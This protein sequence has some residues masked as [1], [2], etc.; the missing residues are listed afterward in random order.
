MYFGIFNTETFLFLMSLRPPWKVFVDD[1]TKKSYY[2]N[3]ETK[4]T[5]WTLPEDQILPT[6][7][8]VWVTNEMGVVVS[9]GWVRLG[10]FYLCV[11]SLQ[12]AWELPEQVVRMGV[13]KEGNTQ[14]GQYA[15]TTT[16]GLTE[17]GNRVSQLSL[18]GTR[19]LMPNALA[20]NLP[21]TFEYLEN[22]VRGNSEVNSG[23]PTHK[24]INSELTVEKIDRRRN[25]SHGSDTSRS[26]AAA[27]TPNFGYAD[28]DKPEKRMHSFGL[29]PSSKPLIP[30]AQNPVK[31]EKIK[32]PASGR[33]YYVNVK[34]NESQ[35]D[36][37]S[38]YVD[39]QNEPDARSS[40][41]RSVADDS[42]SYFDEPVSATGSFSGNAL[43]SN[44]LRDSFTRN[45]VSTPTYDARSEYNRA[46]EDGV[47]Y[48]SNMKSY[49]ATSNSKSVSAAG[50]SNYAFR[51]VGNSG[52]VNLAVPAGTLKQ[53]P[54]VLAPVVA[55]TSSV[56]LTFS[57]PPLPS[58]GYSEERRV[59]KK[60]IRDEI[61]KF[62][63]QSF[64]EEH[65]NVF[66]KHSFFSKEAVLIGDMVKWQGDAIYKSLLK[67]S[68]RN[69]A[70]QTFKFIQ[71]FMRDGGEQ[72]RK[73]VEIILQE[74]G[75][76]DPQM[77]DEIFCQLVKQTTSN[78]K[79]ESNFLG[80]KLMVLCASAFAPSRVFE[81]H[82]LKYFAASAIAA[83]G[84]LLVLTLLAEYYVK[85]LLFKSSNASPLTL[86][87]LDHVL[88]CGLNITM[89]SFHCNIDL[90]LDFQ[91]ALGDTLPYPRILKILCESVI[92]L[93]G[94]EQ[95]GIFRLAGNKTEIDRARY[96]LEN[97]LE[98]NP[99]DPNVPADLL[100]Q[101]FRHLPQPLIPFEQFEYCMQVADKPDICVDMINRICSP[102]QKAV[103]NYLAIFLAEMARYVAT[104]SMNIDNLALVFAPGVVRSKSD[105]PSLLLHYSNKQKQFLKNV[106]EKWVPTPI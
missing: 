104:T 48:H 83:R 28:D 30:P 84:D 18:S 22:T 33:F 93:G 50:N 67:V 54:S 13:W 49:P 74:T 90:I 19:P 91:L 80:W 32:D 42:V 58:T 1:V 24:R 66:N 56:P 26:I 8:I 82:L 46:S 97:G 6:A 12:T 4:L 41:S 95:Q 96:A 86:A 92:S 78:P 98:F 102:A 25:A 106:I 43:G 39:T 15:S 53:G 99:S 77:R 68:N 105:D 70:I 45:G 40:M 88:A 21:T 85:R 36:P 55:R 64:A 79:V 3:E 94:C 61:E 44:P 23:S 2:Y 31:Y 57:K 38:D 75:V 51:S 34:T 47:V 63:M 29:N 62:Q 100:K 14:V 7:E 27:K 76:K 101:W 65:F 89:V 87:A 103:F 72:P 60:E 35:W 71:C 69:D 81:N 17:Q 11:T 20:S 52:S 59:L 37:P 73:P 9:S 5:Q 10:K 16:S